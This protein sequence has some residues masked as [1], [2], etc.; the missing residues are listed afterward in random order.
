LAAK[1][2]LIEALQPAGY[3]FVT[4]YLNFGV[5]NGLR[6]PFRVIR[7]VSFKADAA[8]HLRERVLGAMN[9]HQGKDAA[10]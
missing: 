7:D 4:G 1:T 2:G 10:G 8:T 3:E 9:G 6:R 5:A